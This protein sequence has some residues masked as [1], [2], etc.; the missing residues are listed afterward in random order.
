MCEFAG[1]ERDQCFAGYPQCAN[2]KP[3]VESSLDYRVV[4]P[5][6]NV[7]RV[8]RRSFSEEGTSELG[9]EG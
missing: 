9:L 7:S 2:L 3:K 5:G 8:L 4:H 6:G 1:Q